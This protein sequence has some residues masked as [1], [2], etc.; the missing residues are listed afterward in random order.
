MPDTDDRPGSINQRPG[1]VQLSPKRDLQV[2]AKG[3]PVRER[4]GGC[5]LCGHLH[6]IHA[7]SPQLKSAT[8]MA[9]PPKPANGQSSGFADLVARVKPAVVS[10]RVKTEITPQLMANDNEG[11]PFQGTPFEKFFKEFG[12]KGMAEPKGN[13]H[14]EFVQ[15]Q[16]SGFFISAD[17][18]IVTNHHVVDKAVKVQIVTDDGATLDAKVIGTDPRPIWR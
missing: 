6:S 7:E 13:G 15:G 3:R 2:E 8:A 12:G 14:H 4:R 9:A 18:Y 5:A 11:R 16:G 10:V 17:G 1:D